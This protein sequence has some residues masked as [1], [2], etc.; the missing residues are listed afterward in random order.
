AREDG[1]TLVYG[2]NWAHYAVNGW[3]AF[4]TVGQIFRQDADT[5]FTKSSGLGGTTSDIL[6][7]GQLKLSQDLSL[8]TRGLLNGSLNFSKAEFRGDWRHEKGALSG[9]YLWLG[10]DPAEGRSEETSEMWFDG[11][12]EISPA[13]RASANLRYDISDAQAT[14]AGI[15]LAYSNECVTVD[16]SLNRRYTSTTSVEPSTDFGF[17]IALNGFSVNSGNKKYRRSCSNT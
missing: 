7:A 3:Q 8:T 16:V 4:A 1:L 14:R 9:T 6:M 13:W 17:T 5:R 12:Y 15:G 11:S 10:T 2:V